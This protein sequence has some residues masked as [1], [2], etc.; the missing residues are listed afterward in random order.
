MRSFKLLFFTLSLMAFVPNWVEARE[1]QSTMSS[2]STYT[3][4]LSADQKI[5]LSMELLG[6]AGLYSFNFDYEALSNIAF[7]AGISSYG[8]KSS[9]AWSESAV[10]A[11]LIPLYAHYYLPEF[12]KGHRFYGSTGTTL[13]WTNAQVQGAGM[14][15]GSG[16]AAHLGAGYEYKNSE[17]FVM[18]VSPYYFVGKAKGGW[19]GIT[20]GYSI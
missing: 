19:L 15:E 5:T 18:R 8:L 3:P 16:L 6:K 20:L 10:E 2:E 12:A 4:S 17:G 7:G 9:N 14:I 11:W 13:I 1:W